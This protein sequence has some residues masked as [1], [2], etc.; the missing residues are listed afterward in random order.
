ME[1]PTSVSALDGLTLE[2][3]E[4]LPSGSDAGL[5]RVRGRWADAGR[6]E[7]ELPR[8]VL[9]RGHQTR[10][11]TSLPDARFNREP[12]LW[13]A[14]FLVPAALMEPAAGELALV[15][16]NGARAVL[17][18][19][20]RGFQPPQ[21]VPAAAEPVEETGGEVIDRAVM[22]ERRARRA[23]AA[24]RT[25]AQ[26]AADALKAVEVLE[27]R[28]AELERRLEALQA[29]R[30]ATERSLEAVDAG[31]PQPPEEDSRK[32]A[33]TVA[34]ATVARL[35]VELDEQRRRLRK[36]ELLRSADAVALAS[37]REQEGRVRL[38]ERE[39][40]TSREELEQVRVVA[41]ASA[42]AARERAAAELA[43]IAAELARVRDALASVRRHAEE[44]AA[45]LERRLAE[46]DA[47]L[48]AERRAREAV[49]G[50]LATARTE[51]A[52][53]RETN[54]AEAVAR[55]ALEEELER[56]RRA[57]AA[58]AAANAAERGE[59]AQVRADLARA[60]PLRAELVLAREHARVQATVAQADLAAARERGERAEAE[61]AS[62]REQLEAARA[63]FAELERVA[64]IE[65]PAPAAAP[66]AE[67]A[68]PSAGPDAKAAPPPRAEPVAPTGDAAAP[69]L[70]S[71]A[72]RREL[73]KDLDAAAAALRARTTPLDP[74]PRPGGDAEAA[75]VARR[76]Y[77]WLRGA[78]ARLAHDDPRTAARLLLALVPVQ[79]TLLARALEYDLTIAGAGTYAISSDG[80]HASVRPLHEPRPRA[81]AAFHVAADAA[82]LAELLAGLQ[83]RMGR[84]IGSVRVQGRR[85]DAEAL[86]DALVACDLDLA[87]A[88][89]AGAD[90]EPD[91]VWRALAHAIDPA[92]T[93]GHT[94]TVAQ[95]I[96]GPRPLRW[97]VAVRDG[98]PVTVARRAPVAPPDAVVSMSRATFACLLR[99][100]PVPGGARPVIRGDRAAVATL[101]GWTDR[102]QGR[103]A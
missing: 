35:R 32:E 31:T 89:R 70:P 54:R 43:A 103:T 83:K 9:R 55:G 95:E 12:V 34:V 94:F 27:L 78:L 51:I 97:H 82:T 64:L 42:A 14:T 30:P 38:L 17:P 100:E 87:S 40:A 56:E 80:R 20:E 8:L 69:R 26:R 52:A 21:T 11:F 99:D 53:L 58:L 93:R 13:R 47:A 90:L 46:L 28:S 18:A 98:A 60:A 23:E 15:W 25:Q 29:N 72:E 59:L 16:A 96:A 91:L 19:P 22:A 77:P 86:R 67:P 71:V 74:A 73:S 92:W 85:R 39:L 68:A 84:W 81:Q 24:E 63:A 48:A 101:K 57:R 1:R 62:V 88:A 66:V 33:L 41:E 7:Q 65:A 6:R 61:L 50:A 2:A 75:A 36:S 45:G 10:E 44:R 76:E 37:L 4:W 5:V 3:V 102:A 79:G 49:A